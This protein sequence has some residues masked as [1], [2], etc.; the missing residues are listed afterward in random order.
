LPMGTPEK[1]MKTKAMGSR[2][3]NKPEKCRR[4]ARN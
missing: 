2:K 4:S 3:H 1:H